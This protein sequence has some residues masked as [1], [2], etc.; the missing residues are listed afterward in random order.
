MTALWPVLPSVGGPE[1]RDHYC[2]LTR[3]TNADR[4]WRHGGRRGG[5]HSPEGDE[6]RPAQAGSTRRPG[7]A[8]HRLA[9]ATPGSPGS[10]AEPGSV[11]RRAPGPASVFASA[12]RDEALD[13]AFEIK[14]AEQVTEALG[15]MKGAVMKLGQMVS[16]LDQ[17]LPEH[18]RAALAELQQDAPPMSA[19]LAAGVIVDE[20]GK[21]PDD[22]FD[23]WDP[24]PI[25]SASIG[26]VHRA[27]THD[28]QAVAVKVQYPGVADAVASD[29]DSVGLLFAGMGQLF[30]G[31]D[32][33][34]FVA[35]LRDAT[36]RG[37]RLRERGPQPDAV[38]R[39]LPR[40]PVHPRSDGGPAVLDRPGADHR[41]RRGRAVER[42]AH[43][44]PGRARTSR[45]R[46]STASR[47]ARSTAAAS[48]TATPTRATT[49]SGPAARSPSSTSVCAGSSPATSCS[50]SRT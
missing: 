21:E 49:S 39:L 47:S 50:R 30:P 44:G 40:P 26:Q 1:P 48:S 25:A 32:H 11:V 18:V 43:V 2:S 8:T 22:L 27:I 45:P 37:A 17:G 24:R 14:T 41:A 42:A 16:Y 46:R 6:R 36:G 31:F 29:L 7:G 5:C 23:E 33:K 28:G 15:Q 35:E 9:R 4:S 3:V 34:P 38:R 19:E 20:L 12:E 13:T 10:G